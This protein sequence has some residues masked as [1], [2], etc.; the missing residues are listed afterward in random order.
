MT[1]GREKMIRG[2]ENCKNGREKKYNGAAL[3]ATPPRRRDMDP[4]SFSGEQTGEVA[5]IVVCIGQIEE[6]DTAVRL[7]DQSCVSN[8][9]VLP[10][11]ASTIE[12]L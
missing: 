7:R 9:T 1:S 8:S 10:L 11:Q 6:H 2:R 12:S 5:E 4:R 3:P